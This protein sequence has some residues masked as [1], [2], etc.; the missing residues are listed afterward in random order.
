M[1]YYQLDFISVIHLHMVLLRFNIRLDGNVLWN[2]LF[3]V[4]IMVIGVCF[5]WAVDPFLF[6]IIFSLAAPTLCL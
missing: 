4:T 5:S 1:Y 3:Q 2:I 6:N